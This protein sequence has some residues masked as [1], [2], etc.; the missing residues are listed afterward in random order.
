MNYPNTSEI[1]NLNIGHITSK[2]I[3][4]KQI[5]DGTLIA[6]TPISEV[7]LIRFSTV[8]SASN[9]VQVQ[10]NNHSSLPAHESTTELDRGP[11]R[12]EDS[13]THVSLPQEITYSSIHLPNISRIGLNSTP[14][15]T[16]SNYEI[17]ESTDYVTSTGSTS[18]SYVETYPLM[19]MLNANYSHQ[20]VQ[21]LQDP[22]K[23]SSSDNIFPN[24]SLLNVQ[25]D[26]ASKSNLHNDAE[27]VFDFPNLSVLNL[28][29]PID[30]QQQELEFAENIPQL[31]AL[32]HVST[33]SSDNAVSQK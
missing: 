1:I 22:L 23:N 12:R 26:E 9:N 27:D 31:S 28:T 32:I 8:A 16:E 15:P 3:H 11:Q 17:N 20:S 6:D 10:E 7:D 19:S 33:D 13:D 5:F 30:T 2:E 25:S 14:N 21:Q 29:R 4:N 24:V 18:T